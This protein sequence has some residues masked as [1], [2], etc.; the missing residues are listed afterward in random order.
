M[1]GY[2]R[3]G[4]LVAVYVPPFEAVSNKKIIATDFI[5]NI[6]LICKILPK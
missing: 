4:K 6:S 5:V 2:G 1:R 3:L